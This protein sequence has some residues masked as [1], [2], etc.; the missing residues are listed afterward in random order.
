M[1]IVSQPVQIVIRPAGA[2]AAPYPLPGRGQVVSIAGANTMKDVATAANGWG[3][4]PGSAELHNPIYGGYGFGAFARDYSPAGAFVIAGIGGHHAGGIWGGFVF[5][6]TTAKWISKANANG[7]VEKREDPLKDDVDWATGELVNKPP[8]G[9]L[10]VPGHGY[11][12]H[13]CPPKALSGGK[14]G[15]MIR[16]AI[17]AASDQGWDARKSFKLDLDT[18]LWTYASDNVMSFD[19]AYLNPYT[20]GG[21]DWD[22]KTERFYSPQGAKNGDLRYLEK[23]GSVPGWTWKKVACANLATSSGLSG[24]MVD[25]ERRLL[26]LVWMDGTVQTVDLENIGAGATTRTIAG[27][28]NL[29]VPAYSYT[30]WHK[31]PSADGGDDCFYTIKG[32]ANRAGIASFPNDQSPPTTLAAEQFLY[33]LDPATWTASKVEIAGGILAL[34]EYVYT[35]DGAPPHGNA[36]VYVPALR[37]FAWFPRG[38]VPPQLIKP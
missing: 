13:F 38:D 32:R 11:T 26:V 34:W 10:P 25:N 37:C 35:S 16:C 30:R 4:Y 28:G 18:G 22:P 12:W 1:K 2:F 5:D 23:N 14:S 7:L 33:K 15:Y 27:A 31:W 9:Q 24:C 36:F 6:F 20:D 19:D 3:D 29:P 17:A 21:G 8:N